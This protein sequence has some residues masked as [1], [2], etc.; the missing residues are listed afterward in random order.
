VN[1][2]LPSG[3]VE[4]AFFVRTGIALIPKSGT[5]PDDFLQSKEKI[6][7]TLRGGRVEADERWVVV[8]VYVL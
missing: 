4:T 5:M 7:K 8:K 6:S 1:S 2:A 3:K